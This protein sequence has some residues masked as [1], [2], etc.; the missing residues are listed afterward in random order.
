MLLKKNF[1][2]KIVDKRRKKKNRYIERLL[3][4]PCSRFPHKRKKTKMK[5]L[6]DQADYI[7]K[8]KI[9]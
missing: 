3:S 5:L 9:L 8:N 6:I 4:I 2:K 7:L 1:K